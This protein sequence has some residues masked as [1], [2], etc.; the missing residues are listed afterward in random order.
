[1]EIDDQLMKRTSR[2]KPCIAY[3]AISLDQFT[4][5]ISRYPDDPNERLER[6]DLRAKIM[7]FAWEGYTIDI[8]RIVLELFVKEFIHGVTESLKLRKDS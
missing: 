2:L 3:H 8:R 1:M 6:A 5:L 4:N 7:V